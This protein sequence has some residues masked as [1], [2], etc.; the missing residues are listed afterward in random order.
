MRATGPTRARYGDSITTSSA[1]PDHSGHSRRIASAVSVSLVTW[2]A[3]ASGDTEFAKASAWRAGS[4]RRAIG[5]ITIGLAAASATGGH[6]GEL[7]ARVD[8]AV[9]RRGS[10]ASAGRGAGW[11]ARPSTR[12]PGTCSR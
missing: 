3:V 2:T 12:P 4:S 10:R 9:V 5:T 1:P 6:P 7:Q 8:R 11:R